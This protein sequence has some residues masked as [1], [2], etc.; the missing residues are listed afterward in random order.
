MTLLKAF[1]AANAES[2]DWR[3]EIPKFLLAYRSTPHSTT[4]KSPAEM[5]FNRQIRTKLPEIIQDEIKMTSR[6]EKRDT[7]MK[8]KG[9]HIIAGKLVNRMLKLETLYY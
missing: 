4:G 7:E 3:K 2:R 5:L 8:E 6:R 1:R 9:M